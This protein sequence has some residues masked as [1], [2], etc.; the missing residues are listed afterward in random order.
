MLISFATHSIPH[1]PPLMQACR[2]VLLSSASVWRDGQNYAILFVRCRP[3]T[4]QWEGG[5]SV[6][7]GTFILSVMAGV[8]ADYISKWLD[9]RDDGDEPE[10]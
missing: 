6:T 1:S 2:A 3:Y 5:V 8:I 7:L 9:E 10:R 4:W